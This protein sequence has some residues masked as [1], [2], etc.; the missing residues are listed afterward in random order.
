MAIRPKEES[1]ETLRGV[2]ILLVVAAHVVG[3]TGD[4]GMR[5]EGDSFY[6]HAYFSLSFLRLPLFTVISGYVYS[7]RP[8]RTGSVGGFLAG[9]AR[10]ILLPLLC[11]ASLQYL[12]RCI[13]PCARTPCEI[14]GIWT[15]FVYSFD[16]FWFLQAV[17]LVFLTVTAIDRLSGMARIQHWLLWLAAS[18]TVG[19]IAPD[20]PYFAFS[21]YL[22]LLPY[23][24]LGC[25]LRRFA[26]T[27]GHPLVVAPM[28]AALVCG[29]VV[30][31]LV[32]FG[33]SSV[34]VERFS[35]LAFTVGVSGLLVLFRFRWV[36]RWL[37][38]IGFFAYAI[39][40]FHQFFASGIRVVL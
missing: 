36:T 33:I 34:S 31:Q 26:A 38:R 8:V 27:L 37:A 3:T 14:G 17:F 29:I 22:Y 25:G 35:P 20:V 11:V 30:Q 15:V 6:R 24:I 13:L 28:A 39:F 2:A 16:Q 32:W 12:A 40:L 21:G 10:R 19:W 18:V 9:K 4:S 5:V 23:F 1:I 7:L